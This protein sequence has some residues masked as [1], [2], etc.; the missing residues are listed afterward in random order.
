LDGEDRL[1]ACA[2]KEHAMLSGKTTARI[3]LLALVPVLVG[4]L[5][6]FAKASRA[7]HA[8]GCRGFEA[9][10]HK[11]FDKGD[12]AA[13]SA[14][15]APGD[16]VQLAI[17]FAGPGYRWEFTG[18]LGKVKKADVTGPV[19]VIYHNGIIFKKHISL[20][21]STTSHTAYGDIALGYGRLNVEIDVT[22]A[23]AGAIAISKTGGESSSAP[24]K[25]ASASCIAAA[26]PAA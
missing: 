13:L 6:S 25:F 22:A 21:G 4:G 19:H 26:V 2:F 20:F 9:E 14:S 23:G 10:A 12:T 24:P 5:W 18:V 15:F 1:A 7:P 8:T 11:M 16:R 3:A 17:D